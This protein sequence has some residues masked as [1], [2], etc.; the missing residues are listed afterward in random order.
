MGGVATRITGDVGNNVIANWASG[1][2]TLVY[3]GA[4]ANLMNNYYTGSHK[5]I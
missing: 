5:V 1:Y 4:W 3:Y 2:V